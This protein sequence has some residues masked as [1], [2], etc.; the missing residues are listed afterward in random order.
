VLCV[1]L[2]CMSWCVCMC[3]C[4]CVCVYLSSP[5]TFLQGLT[6]NEQL[7]GEGAEP[8][9]SGCSRLAS[10]CQPPPPSL[11]RLRAVANLNP[12][13]THVPMEHMEAIYA[14]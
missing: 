5:L 1:C 7:K 13:G 8:V 3:M 4:V 10:F 12:N 14:Q 2:V 9:G 11:L 6:T